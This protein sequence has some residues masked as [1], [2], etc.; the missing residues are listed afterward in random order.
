VEL[1][2]QELRER[3]EIDNR[4]LQ[5]KPPRETTL[6]SKEGAGVG[7]GVKMRGERSERRRESQL[8]KMGTLGESLKCERTK[9]KFS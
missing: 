9:M 3:K 1:S 6:L 7:A 8:G 5:E 2:L 4:L